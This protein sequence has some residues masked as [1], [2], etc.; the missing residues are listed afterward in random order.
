MHMCLYCSLAGRIAV[1]C[2]H[3]KQNFQWI[4]LGL[5]ITELHTEASKSQMKKKKTSE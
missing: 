2:A 3:R 4:V 5:S 1:V